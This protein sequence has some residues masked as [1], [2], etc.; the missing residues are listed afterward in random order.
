MLQ[1]LGVALDAQGN[2]R[3]NLSA[4]MESKTA[5]RQ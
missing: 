4:L 1:Q 5:S 2:V 3:A